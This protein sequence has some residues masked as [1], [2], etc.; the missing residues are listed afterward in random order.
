VLS[1]YGVH[2]VFVEQRVPAE[3]PE[4]AA[5]RD[6]VEQDWRDERRAKF[7]EEFYAQL[8]A[9]YEVVV[10]NDGASAV[11]GDA[12]SR[13]VTASHNA[14]ASTDVASMPGSER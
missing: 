4:F 6:R 5:V 1:G 14:S 9:R 13:D 12:A 3:T 10:E 2:W 8:R 7:N 11:Q